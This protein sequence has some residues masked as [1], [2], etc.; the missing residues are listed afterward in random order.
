MPPVT[1][2]AAV[3]LDLLGPLDEVAAGKRP[4]HNL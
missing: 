3:P 1:F 4:L 2:Q